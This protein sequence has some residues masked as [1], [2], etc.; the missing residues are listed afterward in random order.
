MAQVTGQEAPAYRL[1]KPDGQP[2]TLDD[3]VSALARA[4]V[5]FIGESH[6]DAGAHALQLDLLRAAYARYGA[7]GA[8]EK[9]QIVLSLEM[10]ERDVQLVLDEYLA[11]LIPE[12]QFLAC[13][14]PWNNYQSDYRPLVEFAKAHRLPVV[15]ANAPRRYVNLVGREGRDALARLSKTA[16]SFLPPLPYGLA[17]AEYEAKFQRLMTELHGSAGGDGERRRPNLSRMLD[18]QSLWDASMAHAIAEALAASPQPLVLHVNGRFHSEEGMGIPEHLAAY[19][20][21]TRMLSV[22]VVADAGDP[23]A[24]DVARFGKLGDFVAL[25]VK[26]RS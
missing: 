16:R 21:G 3:L 22:T 7:D 2:A 20:K 9:R 26:P 18:S 12:S 4:E 5:V 1:Y 23:E 6:D 15:A 19:R 25:S 13:S 8:V 10:F 17:S 14:R 24:F 11:G